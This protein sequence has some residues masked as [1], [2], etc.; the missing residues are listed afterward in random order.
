MQQSLSSSVRV[1]RVVSDLSARLEQAGWLGKGSKGEHGEGK[2]LSVS[3][4]SRID[5]YAGY[6]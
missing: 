5:V 4:A 2:S 1:G 3:N 6:I